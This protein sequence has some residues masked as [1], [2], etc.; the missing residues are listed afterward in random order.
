VEQQDDCL[1][2]Q[3]AGTGS[4]VVTDYLLYRRIN[5]DEA[6]EVVREV[7]VEG[8]NRGLYELCDDTL[9]ATASSVEY[10]LVARDLYGNTSQLSESVQI[11][12]DVQE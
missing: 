5:G 2:L 12:M 9:S 10:A 1:H 4:D 6:W 11:Q 3:W 7:P 8:D